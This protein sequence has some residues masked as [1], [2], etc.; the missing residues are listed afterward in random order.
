MEAINNYGTLL[1]KD[2]I[3][4]TSQTIR[5]SGTCK[6]ARLFD[7]DDK[8]DCWSLQLY[9]DEASQKVFDNSGLKLKVKEDED[10]LNFQLRRKPE[11]KFTD[12]TKQL[13]PPKVVTAEGTEMDPDEVRSIGNGSTVVC[14][15][16]IYNTKKYGMGHRLNAVRV[17][18]HVVYEPKV[19]EEIF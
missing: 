8:Y 6:W 14:T 16:E 17:M 4:M 10:G 11:V 12:E 2:D 19:E 18:D 5:L 9:P 3:R 15:V 13:N 7:K 1:Q